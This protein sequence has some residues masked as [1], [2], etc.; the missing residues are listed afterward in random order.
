M[1][2]SYCGLCRGHGKI[3]VALRIS[4]V[5]DACVVRFRSEG[6]AVGRLPCDTYEENGL[7]IAALPVVDF[8]QA[9]VVEEV[10][11]SGAVR[12]A[13][14]KKL[15]ARRAKWESRFRYRFDR[16]LVDV[17]RNY[18]GT[19][20]FT[21]NH[22][23]F[24]AAVPDADRFLVRAALVVSGVSSP[25]DL[26]ITCIG[27]DGRSVDVGVVRCGGSV[28]KP[29]KGSGFSYACIPVSISVPKS[30]ENYCFEIR[31]VADPSAT[32]FSVLEAWLLGCMLEDFGA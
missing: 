25:E 27:T 6:E 32:R 30:L 24:V 17:I 1:Q 19:F 22:L 15:S 21:E 31:D 10:D 3:F 4:S 26:S 9:L 12:G 5:D 16:E 20:R 28:V 18:D 8:D 14:R 2:V 7:R 29:V 11:S 13:F 23:E